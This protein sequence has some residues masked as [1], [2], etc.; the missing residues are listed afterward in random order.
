[1]GSEAV[2]LLQKSLE[3]IPNYYPSLVDIIMAYHYND[4]KNK[5][6]K[7]FQKLKQLYPTSKA[8]K[9]FSNIISKY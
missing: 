6:I 5:V 2:P 9:Y 4:K 3:I 8:I 1:M 7:S